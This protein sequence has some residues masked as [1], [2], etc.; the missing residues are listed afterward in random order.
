MHPV[1]IKVF[2]Q[3]ENTHLFDHG[4]STNSISK[5][6]ALVHGV[7]YIEG[8]GTSV[9][10]IPNISAMGWNSNIKGNCITK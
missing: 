1:M 8:N 6:K 4:P 10:F 7:P 3:E 5:V 2:K 9:T